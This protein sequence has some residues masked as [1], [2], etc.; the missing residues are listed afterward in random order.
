MRFVA[1]DV[2]TANADMASVCSIGAAIFENG[3]LAA[4]WYSLID[5]KDYFDFLNISIHG[6]QESDVVG[7]P[8]FREVAHELDRLVSDQVVVTHTH[9]DRVAIQ[10][11]AARWDLAPPNCSWLDSARVARRT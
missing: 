11:A 3:A 5:P 9:F 10:Q 4:E 8:T 6:I 2:E 7:A 1:V